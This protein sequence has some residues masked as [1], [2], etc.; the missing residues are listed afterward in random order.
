VTGGLR[1]RRIHNPSTWPKVKGKN[2]Y[3]RISKMNN[4]GGAVALNFV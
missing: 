3:C 4:Y 2:D 1:N